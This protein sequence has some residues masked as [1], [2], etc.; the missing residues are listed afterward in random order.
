MTAPR[1]TQMSCHYHCFDPIGHRASS[2]ASLRRQRSS[3]TGLQV[4]WGAVEVI[5]V[6]L[7]ILVI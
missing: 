4:G 1:W 2:A 6:V 7:S 5:A 3:R